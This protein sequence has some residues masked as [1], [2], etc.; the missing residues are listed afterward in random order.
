MSNDADKPSASVARPSTTSLDS[1]PILNPDQT[2]EYLPVVPHCLN[3]GTEIIGNFCHVCGQQAESLK[4]RLFPLLKE[5][6]GDW[7]GFDSVFWRTLKQLITRPGLL[8]EAHNMGQRV[9]YMAPTRLYLLVSIVF[10]FV[11]VN[12]DPI[13]PD[14]L[15]EQQLIQET[16]AE[17]GTS[18]DLFI[19]RWD[20][21][22]QNSLV[23]GM[24]VVIPLLALGM[25]LFYIGSKRYVVEHFIFSTHYCTFFLLAWLPGSLFASQILYLIGTVGAVVYLFMALKRVYVQSVGWTLL[26]TTL[27]TFY[28]LILLFVYFFSAGGVAL[29]MAG[30]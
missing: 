7:L 4:V 13:K 5:L 2:T 23:F 27:V 12:F 28:F 8:T 17:S 3:C 18:Y 9:R 25:K 15:L 16:L 19:D 20:D 21:R 10:F 14:D 22:M 29:S 11:Y 26:K 24:F 30:G 6:I 1:G